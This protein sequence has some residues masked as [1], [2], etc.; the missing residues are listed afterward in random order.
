MHCPYHIMKKLIQ[1]QDSTFSK[2]IVDRKNKNILPPKKRFC[3]T[4]K[5]KKEEEICIASMAEK[6]QHT[7]R[8]VEINKNLQNIEKRNVDII[9]GVIRHL[10]FFFKYNI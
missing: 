9:P 7:R 2:E 8:K 1:K 3:I 10:A 4:L 6:E 5:M